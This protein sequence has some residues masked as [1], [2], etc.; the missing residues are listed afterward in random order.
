MASAG[1][2]P[3][4]PSERGVQG[5]W[6]DGGGPRWKGRTWGA[7]GPEGDKAGHPTF[8]GSPAEIALAGASEAEVTLEQ[9][10]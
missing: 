6:L 1:R 2:R 8:A 9:E 4:G 10:G 5:R 3:G 7:G